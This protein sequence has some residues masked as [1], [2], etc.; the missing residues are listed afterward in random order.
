MLYWQLSSASHR[1]TAT[2]E[3]RQRRL[4]F[5]WITV[6]E[7]QEDEYF[8]YADCTHLMYTVRRV[9]TADC[10]R[11]APES[12]TITC[13]LAC[14]ADVHMYILLCV[15]VYGRL[16]NLGMSQQQHLV[17]CT[18]MIAFKLSCTAWISFLPQAS[19]TYDREYAWVSSYKC[20]TGVRLCQS[21]GEFAKRNVRERVQ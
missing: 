18:A 7:C 16:P 1:P 8:F 6:M 11:I 20:A 13:P 2:P 12:M 19:V 15:T 21:S 14:S 3:Q 5:I 17:S 10:N 4:V 9:L